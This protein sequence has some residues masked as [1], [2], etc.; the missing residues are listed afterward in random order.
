MSLTPQQKLYYYQHP[1]LVEGILKTELAKKRQ[2]V[3]GARAV[4]IQ[5]PSYLGRH[6]EDYDVLTKK[7]EKEAKALVS[8][9]NKVYGGEYFRS[10]PAKHKGT[11]KVK[12]NITE[13][14]VVDYTRLHRPPKVKEINGVRYADVSSIKR[15]L[16]KSLNNPEAEFRKDKDFETIERIK[17]GERAW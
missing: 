16:S 13:K 8:A 14:T 4:N 12:S 7:P 10:E 17:L 1:H 15:A 2:I 6:T 5:N 11:F 9:L 3:Y